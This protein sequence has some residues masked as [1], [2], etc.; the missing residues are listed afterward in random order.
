MSVTPERSLYVR[1]DNSQPFTVEKVVFGG[2]HFHSE[3]EKLV[4]DNP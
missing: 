1:L 3:G 4:L 2:K